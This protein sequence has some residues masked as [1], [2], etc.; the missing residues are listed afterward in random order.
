MATFQAPNVT[1]YG[2][3]PPGTGHGEAGVTQHLHAKCFVPATLAANDVIQF[4][5]IPANAIVTGVTLV[6]DS[7]LDSNGSPTLAFD[8]GIVGTTQL[9]KAAV[10]TVGHAA[11]VTGDA[12]MAS[13]GLLYK[14]TSGAKLLIEAVCHTVAATPVA[15]TLEL[16]LAYFVEDTPGSQA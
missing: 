7:Q 10:T 3:Q 12:T 2:Y 15:G 5:Y 14:N 11:G 1:T 9:W 4:G 8:V 16:D 13:A 6:A